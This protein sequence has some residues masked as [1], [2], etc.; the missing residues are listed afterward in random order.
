MMS[1]SDLDVMQPDESDALATSQFVAARRTERL[2]AEATGEIEASDI[3][4]VLDPT[5]TTRLAAIVL[6]PRLPSPP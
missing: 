3:I 5:R 6:T 4:E 1:S 2:G